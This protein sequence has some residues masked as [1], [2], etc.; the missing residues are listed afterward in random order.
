[1]KFK[2]WDGTKELELLNCPFCGGE[3]EVSHIGN[4]HTKTRKIKIK[5]KK[6]RCEKV[7]AAMRFNFEWLEKIV[8]ESWNKRYLI[9]K[10]VSYEQK[11][12]K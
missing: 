11:A 3:P 12:A 8:V 10:K 6:C 4:D 7:D 9:K 1:V 2:T 5:C